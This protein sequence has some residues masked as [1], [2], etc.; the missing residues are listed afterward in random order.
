MYRS[1]V[2][3]LLAIDVI[4]IGFTRTSSQ[5]IEERRSDRE[6]ERVEGVEEREGV[7]TGSNRARGRGR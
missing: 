7:Y 2:V 4:L 5:G 1:Y 6:R 3:E